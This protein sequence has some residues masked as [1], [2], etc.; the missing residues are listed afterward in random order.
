MRKPSPSMKRLLSLFTA[1]AVILSLSAGITGCSA[2][3][4]EDAT[5]S[6]V[7]KSSVSETAALTASAS[8]T[9]SGETSVSET[10]VSKTIATETTAAEV[11]PAQTTPPNISAPAE[12]DSKTPVTVTD[13]LGREV[14]ISQK[15]ET[16]ISGY[17]I[18]SSLLIA[19]GQA[20][21]VAGVEAQAEKRPIYGLAAPKLLDLPG[22]GTVKELDLELCASLEPDLVI[23]PAKL[24]EKIPAMEELG[25]TVLVVDPENRQ[26]MKEMTELLGTATYSRE[27]AQRLIDATD[28]LSADLRTTLATVLEK[29]EKPTVYL[30][31]NSSFF[32]T[33]GP[34]MYQ[35]SLIEQAGGENVAASLSDSY[36]SK[37]SYEQLLAWDPDYIILAANAA[38]SVD[39]IL[40]DEQLAEC[41]AVKNGHVYQ[42]PGQ[43]EAWDSPVPGS[44]LGS[45]W[46]ASVLHPEAC[47]PARYQQAV[48]AFYEEFY[49]FTPEI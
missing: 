48:T 4:P 27:T 49:G 36:W 15:P 9:E 8:E 31:G 40:A 30:G 11:S 24:K 23:I 22:V 45:L 3:T 16:I 43:I 25:L 21:R 28:K 33:A 6:S 5:E 47:S 44:V 20:D 1:L 10:P 37:I 14:V 46:L 26:L 19:L 29:E 38:Y 39:S 42:I 12:P 18:S 13:Q 32:S 35:H 7:S 34:S 41:A 2:R 17:Y